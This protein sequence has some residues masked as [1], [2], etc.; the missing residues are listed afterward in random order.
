MRLKNT[1]PL[2]S[3][4]TTA[5]FVSRLAFAN[6]VPTV[7]DLLL[8]AEVTMAQF[9][10]GER[11]AFE[12]LEELSGVAADDLMQQ[13][14]ILVEPHVYEIFGHRIGQQH[15]LRGESR[16]CPACFRQD[17]RSQV[18]SDT[19]VLSYGRAL[20][21]I[22]SAR[23][24]PIHKLALVSAPEASVKHEF[25]DTWTPWMF[26]IAEGEL[27]QAID[28][29]GMY[30]EHAALRLA[31][32]MPEGWARHFSLGALGAICEILG[33]SQTHGKA[34]S[35]REVST[36]D[37]AKAM[38]KGFRLI[39]AGPTK[40]TAY[41]EHLRCASGKPQDRPQARYGRIYDWLKRGA[42]H[43][44]DFEPLRNILRQH[45]LNTWPL[46]VGEQALDYTLEDRRLHSIRT[47]SK[48]HNLHPKRLRRI[49]MDAQI[50]PE[51]DLPDFEVVFDADT[52]K[53][54]L[55]QASGSVAFSEAQKRL[56]LTRSQLDTLIKA[57]I[58]EPGEGGD[59]A[60]PRFTEATVQYWLDY[61]AS[62]PLSERWETLTGIGGAARKHG[63]STSAVMELILNGT[64]KKVYCTKGASG[65]S[66]ILI[67]KLEI[68]ALLKAG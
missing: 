65:F 23:V 35:L 6:G 41:F 66:A 53:D 28:E 27:D 25:V 38:S 31:G 11:R 24:C 18:T 64:L 50:I 1:V 3:D 68:N 57:E 12:A 32:E 46:G 19:M 8:D 67:D 30:E 7:A 5:S 48:K 60:R 63:I 16:I 15:L 61:V 10:K 51:T 20:W 22:A 37:L 49:L 40:I 26:E 55:E 42:G 4:E 54:V 47:A 44:P 21:A 62:F 13:A 33:V 29:G 56:G 52:A 2:H 43:G 59:Q 14:F 17:T 9:L 34:A 36:A 39:N 45:I 58:L